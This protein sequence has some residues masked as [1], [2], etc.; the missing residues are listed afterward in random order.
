MEITI[1]EQTYKVK[2][3]IRALFVFEQ[4][5]GKSFVLEKMMDFYIFYYAM[6]L[7]NNPDCNLLFD[8]FIDQCD[9]NPEISKQFQIYLEDYFKKQSQLLPE[10]SSKKK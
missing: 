6:I 1:K 9:E 3:S 10:E 4:L 8:E 5:T 7:A 2:Y